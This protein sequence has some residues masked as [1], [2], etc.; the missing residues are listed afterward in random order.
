MRFLFLV[1]TLLSFSVPS[2]AFAPGETAQYVVKDDVVNVNNTLCAESRGPLGKEVMGKFTSTV[3]YT[4]N[5]P[6]FKKFKG[7]NLVFN[8]CC[9]MCAAK[10]D[11]KWKE[12]AEE[13]MTFHGMK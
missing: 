1:L 11:G 9:P 6:K 5:D 2:M 13:I 3:K 8:Q 4:G 7:K 10:F 12:N